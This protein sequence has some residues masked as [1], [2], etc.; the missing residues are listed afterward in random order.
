MMLTIN[1]QSPTV[2]NERVLSQIAKRDKFLSCYDVAQG[3]PP[4]PKTYDAY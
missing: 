4:V 1:G 3:E 2:I